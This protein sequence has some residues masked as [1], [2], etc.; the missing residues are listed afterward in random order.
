MSLIFDLFPVLCFFAVYLVSDIY[1]ATAAVIVATLGQVVWLKLRKRK[2]EPVLL[3]TL[4]IV[5]IFGG[6]TIVLHD[7]RFILWKPTILY[8]L[9]SI[10]LGASVLFFK[11]NLIR[12]LFSKAQLTLPDKVWAWLN[13]AWSAFFFLLGFVNLYVAFNYSEATWVKFKTFGLSG[14]LLV[15]G[16]IQALLLARY[17]EEGKQ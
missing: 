10:A 9:F 6:L 5:V 16:V 1:V 7:K 17:A 11:R 13:W 4:A 15:F 3:V 8:W 12:H 14:L 2:I